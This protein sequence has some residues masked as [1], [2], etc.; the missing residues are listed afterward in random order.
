MCEITEVIHTIYTKD[1]KNHETICR[2]FLPADLGGAVLIYR[3]MAQITLKPVR[4]KQ[5]KIQQSRKIRRK[6]KKGK[7]S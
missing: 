3:K 6:E 5:L 1:N 2:P 7:N 4:K